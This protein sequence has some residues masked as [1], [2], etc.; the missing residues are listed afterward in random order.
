VEQEP[1]RRYN[2]VCKLQEVVLHDRLVNI[3]SFLMFVSLPVSLLP[4]ISFLLHYYYY[5]YYLLFLHSHITVTPPHS[6]NVLLVSTAR[7]SDRKH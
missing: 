7:V 4:E 5:Y 2:L 6:V 3:S 1:Q